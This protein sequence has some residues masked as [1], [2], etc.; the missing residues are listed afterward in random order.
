MSTCD[1]V[2][3]LYEQ[4]KDMDVDDSLELVLSAKTKEE[5]DFYSLIGDFFLQSKQKKVIEAKRF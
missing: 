3:A 4:C 5:Q 2:K 1:A